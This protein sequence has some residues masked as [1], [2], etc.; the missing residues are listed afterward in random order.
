MRRQTLEHLLPFRS[1]CGLDDKPGGGEVVLMFGYDLLLC[2]ASAKH[3]RR[4]HQPD[5]CCGKVA[6]YQS[7]PTI[8]FGQS[9][10]LGGFFRNRLSFVLLDD[11]S[12]VIQTVIGPVHDL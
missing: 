7:L 12:N 2:K 8:S 4:G 9:K 5:H 3:Q 1:I 10:K 11:R 6:L